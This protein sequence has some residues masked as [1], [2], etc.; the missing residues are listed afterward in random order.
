M[1]L[2]QSRTQLEIHEERKQNGNI[3]EVPEEK[4]E[5]PGQRKFH[6]QLS[7]MVYIKIY[8]GE[9]QVGR[10]LDYPE[11]KSICRQEQIRICSTVQT[12]PLRRHSI[13][14]RETRLRVE[15]ERPFQ[16][17]PDCNRNLKTVL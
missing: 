6:L 13:P 3:Q 1:Q 17:L 4:L 9:N 16:S 5:S 7:H 10:F 11:S 15:Y 12:I 2:F 14:S 8:N